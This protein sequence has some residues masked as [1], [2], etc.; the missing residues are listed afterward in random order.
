MATTQIKVHKITELDMD[1]V[2]FVDRGANQH[3]PVV[4]FKRY[5]K[6]GHPKP[7]ELEEDKKKKKPKG[8]KLEVPWD[9]KKDMAKKRLE[10]LSKRVS[11]L[12]ARFKPHHLR[13]PSR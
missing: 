5:G 9:E 1:E 6:E 2:S 4:L 10:T 3:A 13:Y 8:E 12:Q 7:A 11:S